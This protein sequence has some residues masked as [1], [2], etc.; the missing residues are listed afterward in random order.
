M[1][2]MMEMGRRKG[3]YVV[4][5]NAVDFVRFQAY[6]LHCVYVGQIRLLKEA[7]V[8]RSHRRVLSLFVS[9]YYR[10]SSQSSLG[11]YTLLV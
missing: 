10:Y 5:V 11:L 4:I 1:Q 8:I 2:D 7:R 6:L 9:L 3:L